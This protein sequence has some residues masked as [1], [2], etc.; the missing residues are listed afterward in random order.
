MVV[1]F[2]K[3]GVWALSLSLF[4]ALVSLSWHAYQGEAQFFSL[5]DEPDA[6]HPQATVSIQDVSVLKSGAGL[7]SSSACTLSESDDSPFRVVQYTGSGTSHV[8]NIRDQGGSVLYKMPN[9]SLVR[10]V[11]GRP[12]AEDNRYSFAEV[13]GTHQAEVSQRGVIDTSEDSKVYEGYVFNDSLSNIENHVFEVLDSEEKLFNAASA[14]HTFWMAKE[15]NDRFVIVDCPSSSGKSKLVVFEVYDSSGSKRLG[16]VAVDPQD[17]SIFRNIKVRTFS[18]TRA[19]FQSGGSSGSNANSGGVVL[20]GDEDPKSGSGGS[21][22]L[23][24]DDEGQSGSSDDEDELEDDDYDA[25]VEESDNEYVIDDVPLYEG[26]MDYMICTSQTKLNVRPFNDVSTVL[27]EANPY[28]AIIP[29]E[30]FNNDERFTQEVDGTEYT[31]LKVQFPDRDNAIGWVAESYVSE[32]SRCVSY[33]QRLGDDQPIVCT[34]SGTVNV[35]NEDLTD[36][37]FQA[38]QFEPLAIRSDASD[39]EKEYKSGDDTYT[40]VPVTFIDRGSEEGWITKEYVKKK[41]EC[42]PYN[43]QSTANAASGGCCNFPLATR[44]THDYTTG[45]RRF[46]ANRSKGKRLHAGVDLYSKDRAPVYA[47]DSGTLRGFYKFY[48]DVYAIE[49]T[50][51]NFIIRYG[52]VLNKMPAGLKVGRPVRMGQNLGWIWKIRQLNVKP[53]LHFEMYSSKRSGTLSGGG[54]YKR[55]SDLKNP[56]SDMRKWERK[57]FGTSY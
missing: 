10:L 26:N 24:Q 29:M 54:K 48:Y 6:R 53:M 11:E 16:L 34:A 41:K 35:R 9:F 27:F 37:L 2:K 47:V 12:A 8:E 5:V 50:H 38:D 30:S 28:E 21:V 39:I 1:R 56:T 32:I 25:N 7:V 3:H 36:V 20:L 17:A 42:T 57:K 33:Q 15:S 19:Y 49:V 22:I 43:T 44:P 46:G 52:E 40:M 4:T 14:K 31:F 23:G 51:N 13:V 45:M 55:R 18:E